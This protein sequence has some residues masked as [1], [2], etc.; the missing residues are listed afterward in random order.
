MI[1]QKGFL[2]PENPHI[3]EFLLYIY[4]LVSTCW[5]EDALKFLQ[6]TMAHGYE[7]PF[8]KKE[9]DFWRWYNR[10]YHFTQMESYLKK[11]D[12]FVYLFKAVS[13]QTGQILGYKIG[14]SNDP[15]RPRARNRERTKGD[16]YV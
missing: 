13:K 11:N 1:D 2:I 5:S 4:K 6:V 3:P 7:V 10:L 8:F 15:E 12:G 9:D 16:T 14:C